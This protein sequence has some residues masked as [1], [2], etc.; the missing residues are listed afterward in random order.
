M[1]HNKSTL[2][3]NQLKQS[4]QFWEEM[5]LVSEMS[6]R[7][8]LILGDKSAD[9]GSTPLPGS[10][11]SNTLGLARS[12][13]G[14]N[15]FRKYLENGTNFNPLQFIPRIPSNLREKFSTQE[16][17][18]DLIGSDSTLLFPIFIKNWLKS[19]KVCDLSDARKIQMIDPAVENYLSYLPYDN[20][21]LSLNEPL[22]DLDS[23][24]DA[25]RGSER[26]YRN[27]FISI[28]GEILKILAV[29]DEIEKMLLN[30]DLKKRIEGIVNLPKKIKRTKFEGAILK[31]ADGTIAWWDNICTFNSYRINMKTGKYMKV[32]SAD[33]D[34][35]WKQYDL[36]SCFLKH[37]EE[38]ETSELVKNL[39]NDWYVAA[40]AL[41]L[42]GMGKLLA[43]YI[44]AEEINLIEF[45]DGTGDQKHKEV[46]SLPTTEIPLK[47]QEWYEVAV[48]NV[49]YIAMA[50]SKKKDKGF[51]IHTG[52]EMPIH[53]R[54][55]HIRHY[56]NGREVIIN[57][58]LVRKDRLKLG[59]SIHGSSTTFK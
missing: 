36:K 15:L 46:A 37:P 40:I 44:P 48:S 5:N 1:T 24:K 30:D 29:P 56:K 55:K 43:D 59:E 22:R 27:F 23:L 49:T 21:I 2:T 11:L 8:Y 16:D 12:I 19:K 41:L 6:F 7:R 32:S 25:K 51:T 45:K 35:G 28:E 34:Y 13:E 53:L 33:Q 18:I 10:E 42:N 58:I 31:V 20:F 54:R 14:Y 17:L 38:M 26:F 57:Q 4:L 3:L 39:Q 47:K 9:K 50:K 52:T